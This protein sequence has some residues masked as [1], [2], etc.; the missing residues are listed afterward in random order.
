M[1]GFPLPDQ[2]WSCQS[3]VQA[4][5]RLP[6]SE[7][8]HQKTYTPY[9]TRLYNTLAMDRADELGYVAVCTGEINTITLDHPC[10]IP[11]VG[12]PGDETWR[13]H[14]EWRRMFAGYSRVLVFPDDDESVT[15]VAG[16]VVGHDMTKIVIDG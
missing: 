12:V 1:N 14:P 2:E 6:A 10:G 7:C 4:V 15:G 5:P 11:A 9:P 13:K 16:H 8:K 3:Q